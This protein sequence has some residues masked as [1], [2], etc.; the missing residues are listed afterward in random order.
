MYQVAIIGAGQLGSR[1]LQG[2][3]I[4]SS[5]LSITVM[6]NNEDSLSIAK[7]RY[8]S[9]NAIGEKN[10]CFVNTMDDMPE[11]LDLV[12]IAT[13]SKPR[14]AIIKAL[15]K[16]SEVKYL[17]LEKVLFPQLSDY[18]EI[19]ELLKEKN[20][21]CWVN[22]PRRMLGSYN[23][24]KNHLDYSN[25]L[26]M[27]FVGHDW[28]LC[29]NSMHYIDVFMYLA[30][31]E[32]YEINANELDRKILQSKRH[33]YIEMNGTLRVKTES[34]DCLLLSSVVDDVPYCGVKIKN[35]SNSF[36]IDEVKG[37]L[38]FNGIESKINTPFQSQTTGII[39]DGVLRTGFCPLSTYEKS[40]LY[41]T[42]FVKKLLEKYNEITGENAKILPIT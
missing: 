14:A 18:D 13:G 17:I 21:I 34:G 42:P 5:P 7:E 11:S 4:A 41:H 40:T 26:E 27:I 1:H 36:L 16:H 3:K 15:L 20:V 9:I 2:L 35:G 28:G 30:Q 38:I 10:A 29:C 31:K 37:L 12:I 23:F 22:C 39:V 6:D 19:G 8:D 25:P 32:K 33:G 24:V